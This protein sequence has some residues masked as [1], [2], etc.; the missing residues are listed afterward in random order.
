MSDQPKNQF[1]ETPAQQRFAEQ[2]FRIR[3][4]YCRMHDVTDH[5]QGVGLYAEEAMHATNLLACVKYLSQYGEGYTDAIDRCLE[6]YGWTGCGVAVMSGD[7]DRR[8]G[9]WRDNQEA[10]ERARNK[11]PAK[12]VGREGR[13]SMAQYRGGDK[14]GT[15]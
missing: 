1:G 5:G 9:L 14:N 11:Q 4:S 2:C 10:I 12:S 15:S 6:Q 3:S 8:I 7:A 13:K